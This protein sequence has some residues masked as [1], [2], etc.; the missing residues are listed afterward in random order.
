M[1]GLNTTASLMVTLN[2]VGYYYP[3]QLSV[4]SA[5]LP[6]GYSISTPAS[7][8]LS[9]S[10]LLGAGQ[11]CQITVTFDPTTEGAHN[12]KIAIPVTSYGFSQWPAASISVSGTGTVVTLTPAS[13]T[14]TAPQGSSSDE[15]LLTLTNTG[16]SPVNITI[17]SF[18]APTRQHS[19]SARYYAPVRP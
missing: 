5:T 6:A 17:I 8:S 7:G 9:C 16:T 19:R 14:F 13:L 4:G 12:G 15:Q 2:S 1:Q 3:A 11:N 18:R 10:N